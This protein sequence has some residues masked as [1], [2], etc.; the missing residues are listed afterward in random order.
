M[1]RQQLSNLSPPDAA[2]ALRSYSRRFDELFGADV[3]PEEQD[4]F[5][6][7][8]LDGW[9]VDAAMSAALGHVQRIDAALA[10]T[11]TMDDPTLEADLFARPTPPRAAPGR[12]TVVAPARQALG[13][14]QVLL[15][16]LADRVARTP[17]KDWSRPA[18]VGS[19]RSDAHELLREAVA[20]GRS[21]LD[22]VAKVLEAARRAA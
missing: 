17:P 14:L 2:V 4:L 20:Y 6:L 7:D 18:S 1:D 10:R 16:A 19:Q 13:S 21:A 11:L 9:S 15:G 12:T 22:L 5:G 8:V 3:D